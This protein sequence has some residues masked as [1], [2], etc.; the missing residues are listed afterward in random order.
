[1][2]I[3]VLRN[4][5]A[6]KKMGLKEIQLLKHINDFDINNKY[7]C[8]KLLDHFSDR[9]HLCLVFEA[10]L[11]GNLREV[12]KKYG[13]KIG[14]SIKA[15]KIY[16]QK[17]MLALKLL[18][19]CKML[20]ADIKLDN[21]LVNENKTSIKLGDFGS[22]S[23]ENENGITPYLVSRFYRAPEI[24]L[25][26]TYS[27]GIDM[28][29][30]G[31][32]LYE[33]ATGKICFPGKSNNEMLYLF[34]EVAGPIN[35]KMQRKGAFT[36]QHFD[37]NGSFKRLMRDKITKKEY[38]K[39]TNFATPMRDL[40]EELLNSRFELSAEEKQMVIN[41]CDLL[42]KIFVIDPASRITVDDA[43]HQPFFKDKK[44]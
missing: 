41:L 16:G 27:Y 21:I 26:Q 28:W 12:L 1:V 30:V 34:M 40:K 20:H 25:G 38:V 23:P 39:P 7:N 19:S 33:I 13:T 42:S 14:L 10:M 4:N 43:L 35:R 18:K 15:V 32:C 2:A 24:V 36:S 17:L 44:V 8:V 3:K 31:C 11:G 9:D 37:E 6:M 5:E 22:A 29:S